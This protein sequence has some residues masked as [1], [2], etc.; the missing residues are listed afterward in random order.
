MPAIAKTFQLIR[1]MHS[2]ED[3]FIHQTNDLQKTLSDLKSEIQ[4]LKETFSENDPTHSCE[5]IGDILW[6]AIALTIIAERYGYGT[7][8]QIINR[9]NH[10]I[11]FRNPHVFKKPKAKKPEE[12]CEIRAKAK[13]DYRKWRKQHPLGNKLNR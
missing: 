2:K 12:I 1:K 4:E 6:D 10:K 9:L 13:E 7:P 3:Y 5:E 8:D 11:V